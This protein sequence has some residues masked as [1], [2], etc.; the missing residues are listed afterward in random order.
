LGNRWD[1][2]LLNTFSCCRYSSGILPF[3]EGWG[4]LGWIVTRPIKYLAS[5]LVRGTFFVR[6]VNIA[7]C[8]FEAHKMIGS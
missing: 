2:S 1:F 7:F 3:S 4:I 5:G 8:A 6:N